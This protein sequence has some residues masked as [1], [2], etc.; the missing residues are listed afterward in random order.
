VKRFQKFPRRAVTAVYGI[1][2]L[3]LFV[4]LAACDTQ[5][6]GAISDF[7]AAAATVVQQ[8]RSAYTVVNDTIV[9]E[10]IFSLA[11]QPG[12]LNSDPAK[13]FPLFLP[14]EDLN[15][16]NALLD[17]LQAYAA[18]L[19]NLTG[20]T[21]SDVDSEATKLGS[22][23]SD[24]GTNERL[25]HSFRQVK[26]VTKEDTNAAATGVDAIAKFLIARKIAAD[27]PA[28]LKKN[29]PH[30]EAVTTL[31][32]HEIGDAPSS[33]DPGGLRGKLSRTYDGLIQ[34]QVTAVN[35]SRTGSSEKQQNV[36]KL[37]E[38]VAGQRNADAAL[39]GTQS[40][41]KKLAAAH[42]ALLHV[43]TAPATF[44]TEVAGLVAQARQA[45]DFYAKLPAK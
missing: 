40:A 39:A 34:G 37:A 23:L 8:T 20:K 10:E 25:Q 26:S 13:A 4:V 7:G 30:I 35:T 6:A 15:I 21:N 16:R 33:D 43:Q 38:L 9:Q 36:A 11:A 24:L 22:S 31:L 45:Q 28:I 42:R 1:V 17:A 5:Y 18:A 29:Q 3:A 32:I 19:G 2:V 12:P 41:L 27:L 14:Q 44:K